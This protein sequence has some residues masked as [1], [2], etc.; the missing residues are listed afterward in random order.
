MNCNRCCKSIIWEIQSNILAVQIVS[1][2]RL[3]I[4]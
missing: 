4:W 1:L 2:R 3:W